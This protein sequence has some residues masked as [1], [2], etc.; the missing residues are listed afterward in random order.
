M[1][2]GAIKVEF[3][4]LILDE[5]RKRSF[6]GSYPK[7]LPRR[8]DSNN[9]L[10]FGMALGHTLRHGGPGVYGF[11]PWVYELI[12][13]LDETDEQIMT[14]ITKHDIPKHAGSIDLIE[15]TNKLD[16]GQSQEEL[17]DI[18]DKFIQIINC[19]RW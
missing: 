9:F 6:E 5:F 2:A 1:D 10:I 7:L 13:E 12:R 15:L 8:G 16:N 18:V 19:S 17:D 14:L 4:E 11:Q 3:F